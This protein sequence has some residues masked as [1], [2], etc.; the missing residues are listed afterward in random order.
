[1]IALAHS[2]SLSA[3][4]LLEFRQLDFCHYNPVCNNYYAVQKHMGSVNI[5]LT[6]GEVG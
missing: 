5:V 6:N 2:V 3:S 4:E 1:M